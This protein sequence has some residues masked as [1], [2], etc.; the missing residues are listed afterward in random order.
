MHRGR[1]RQ[2]PDGLAAIV[3]AAPRQLA[4]HPQLDE[5]K[6]YRTFAL[7][8]S[9]LDGTQPSPDVR[10]QGLQRPFDFRRYTR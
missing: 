9:D 2:S 7:P 4:A 5:L 1:V 6:G 3:D 8:V 10:V